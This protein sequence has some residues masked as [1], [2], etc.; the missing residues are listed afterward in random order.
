MHQP[1]DNLVKIE[2]VTFFK[3]LQQSKIMWLKFSIQAYIKPMNVIRYII[4]PSL[5]KI[6][7]VRSHT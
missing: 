5:V 4:H 7:P 3:F 2:Q 1:S 6:R